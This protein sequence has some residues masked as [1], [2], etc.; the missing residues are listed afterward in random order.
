M[1]SI[2]NI[3]ALTASYQILK[4]QPEMEQQA[5]QALPLELQE[6]VLGVASSAVVKK[7]ILSG[8]KTI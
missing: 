3:H 7:M 5:L 1:N 8:H 2:Q 4:N 6:K